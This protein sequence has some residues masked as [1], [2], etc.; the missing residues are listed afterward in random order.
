MATPNFGQRDT[1]E[2]I[3]QTE[4]QKVEGF[5]EQSEPQHDTPR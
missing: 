3:L 1:P 4:N 2:A 5:P